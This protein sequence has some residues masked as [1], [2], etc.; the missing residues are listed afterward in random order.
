[1]Y[2]KE[3]VLEIMNQIYQAAQTIL[4]RFEPVIKASDF[5]ESPAECNH[6]NPGTTFHDK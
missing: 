5:T 1:M 2:D 4:Q 3:L 6:D